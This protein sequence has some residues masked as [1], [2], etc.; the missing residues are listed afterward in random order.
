M[1][2]SK[3]VGEMGLGICVE[4]NRHLIKTFTRDAKV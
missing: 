1:C 3:C 2:N 4:S